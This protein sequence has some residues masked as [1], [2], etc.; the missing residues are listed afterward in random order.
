MNKILQ[1]LLE[2]GISLQI[3]YDRK[4]EQ[5]TYAVSGFYKS[6]YVELIESDDKLIARARYNEITEIESLQDLVLLNYCWWDLSKDRFDGWKNPNSQW[7][8]LLIKFGY[9]TEET[10]TIKTYK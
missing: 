5:S 3:G 2:T 4:L 9:V 8:P 6:N 10:K 1:E 7:L